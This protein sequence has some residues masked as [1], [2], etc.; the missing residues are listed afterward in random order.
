MS[1]LEEHL[2]EE[3]VRVTASPKKLDCP[4]QDA[5]F[6]PDPLRGSVPSKDIIRPSYSSQIGTPTSSSK[7]EIVHIGR[8]S[9]NECAIITAIGDRSQKALWDSGTGRCII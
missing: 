3:V 1:D 2:E 7:A 6:A 9:Q 8:K 4:S 5:E